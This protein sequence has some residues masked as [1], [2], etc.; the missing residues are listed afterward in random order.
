M[1]P[2]QGIH[3]YLFK[4]LNN[5]LHQFDIYENTPVVAK[6]TFHGT[7]FMG[8]LTFLGNKLFFRIFISALCF[9]QVH[10]LF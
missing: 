1:P 8:G 4:L 6:R 7:T 5:N 2:I 3:S 9:Q 10:R